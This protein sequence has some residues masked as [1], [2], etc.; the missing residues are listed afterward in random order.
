VNAVKLATS[1]ATIATG[2]RPPPVALPA[3]TI[4]RTGRTHGEIAVTIPATNAIARSRTTI[5]S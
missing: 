1:P 4:G 2:L 3:N 5:R